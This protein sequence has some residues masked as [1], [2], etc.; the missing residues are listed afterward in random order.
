MTHSTS[1]LLMTI[2]IAIIAIAAKA[3]EQNICLGEIKTYAVD[4]TDGIGG[5]PGSTY[6]WQV[7]EAGFAGTITT[8]AGVAGNSVDIDW[9]TTPVG[10]YTVEVVETNGTCPGEAVTLTVNIAPSPELTDLTVDNLS[11]CSGSD[12]TFTITG[13]PNSTVTYN[14]DGGT[15]QT[16]VL[17][18]TGTETVVITN[19]T[20]DTTINLVS[21]AAGN[22]EQALTDTITVTVTPAPITSPITF[23]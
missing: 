17:D 10:T 13:T 21:I 5:T 1:K 7:I 20:A 22:C 6:D 18:G 23:S 16:V 11:I 3:Q 8:N 4:E 2:F 14:I 12:I 19:A 9:A 15:D